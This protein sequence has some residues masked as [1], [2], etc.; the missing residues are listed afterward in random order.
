[1]AV[2]LQAIANMHANIKAQKEA[3]RENFKETLFKIAETNNLRNKKI[4]AVEAGAV[5]S[6]LKT[7]NY[8]SSDAQIDSAYDMNNEWL[9]NANS[10]ET[11]SKDRQ[12][13][14]AIY[15]SKNNLINRFSDNQEEYKELNN[16]IDILWEQLEGL[17]TS[18]N[19][20]YDFTTI[21]KVLDTYKKTGENVLAYNQNWIN[22]A[23]YKNNIAEINNWIKTGKKFQKIDVDPFVAGGE[24][25]L[26]SEGVPEEIVSP[27]YE[28]EIQP[29]L[30]PIEVS[31]LKNSLDN[32]S[33]LDGQMNFDRLLDSNLKLSNIADQLPDGFKL[34][35][36]Q[37]NLYNTALEKVHA[38]RNYA[39]EFVSEG[40]NFGEGME[41]SGDI[42][43]GEYSGADSVLNDFY[44][45]A[46]QA[47]NDFLN[48]IQR[49]GQEAIYE[50]VPPE[51]RAAIDP[52][53][54]YKDVGTEGIQLDSKYD[55]QPYYG[56]L[57]EEAY[58]Q[59]K[60]G[61][62][63]LANNTMALAIKYMVEGQRNIDASKMD[64]IKNENKIFEK[65][66]IPSLTEVDI[67]NIESYMDELAKQYSDPDYEAKVPLGMDSNQQEIG[68]RLLFGANAYPEL[69]IAFEETK[70]TNRERKVISE[71]EGITSAMARLDAS[72][73]A[74]SIDTGLKL[75]DVSAYS[76]KEKLYREEDVRRQATA[77]VG[78]NIQTTFDY[79][80]DIWAG[81]DFQ[82]TSKGDVRKIIDGTLVPGSKDWYKSMDRVLELYLPKELN[83]IRDENK[84]IKAWMVDE[85]GGD[86]SK[87][88]ESAK[89]INGWNIFIDHLKAYDIRQLDRLLGQDPANPL[90]L[91]ID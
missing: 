87:I 60:L 37:S 49:E 16:N 29:Q 91:P 22:K 42:F 79:L 17:K 3:K 14:Q 51:I 32:F 62:E 40:G 78:D 20:E 34:N 69:K 54:E 90:N 48:S 26:V 76:K 1:M 65:S 30:D 47:V 8:N 39:Q 2:D 82:E 9:A 7:L 89:E 23:E 53:Y 73:N 85:W 64:N 4:T 84:T 72:M 21:T 68:K 67:N 43:T 28:K 80:E 83:G 55:N 13:N 52:V 63:V 25:V 31:H 88:G 70:N 71:E 46:T 41:I 45:D 15:E 12:L 19:E 24:K 58:E 66:I 44:S 57:M 50:N 81:A 10:R 74:L 6:Y 35:D 56:T 61:D 75:K 86:D 11:N 18:D 36:E 5:D 27:G 38:G 77:A 59:W 33:P